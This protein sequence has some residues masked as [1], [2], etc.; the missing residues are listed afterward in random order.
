MGEGL[1]EGGFLCNEEVRRIVCSS[2]GCS[3]R[4]ARFDSDMR[5]KLAGEWVPKGGAGGPLSLR[6]SEW[7]V[8]TW[9]RRA[10]EVFQSQGSEILVIAFLLVENNDR[11][12]EG[13]LVQSCQPW[14]TY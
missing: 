3:F 2:P 13:Y 6:K 11:N 1:S 12:L 10:R 8:G 4:R 5:E 9:T 7:E 14:S